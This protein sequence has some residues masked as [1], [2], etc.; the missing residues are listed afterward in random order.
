MSR[1][2]EFAAS[3]AYYMD[4]L[5]KAEEILT[6]SSVNHRFVGGVIVGPI[7]PQS[8]ITINTTEKTAVLAK[9]TP[10]T[11]LRNDGTARDIDVIGFSPDPET[12]NQAR[13][14]FDQEAW[15]AKNHRRPYPSISIESTLYPDWNPR[16]RLRQWV[17]T[18]DVDVSGKLHLT[19]GKVD[20]V[21]PWETM[22]PWKMSYDGGLELTT[23]NPFGLTK[24]YEMRNASGIKR[25]DRSKISDLASVCESVRQQALDQGVDFAKDFESWNQFIYNLQNHPDVLTRAKAV[26]TYLYWET[27][28]TPI[29][30][31]RGLLK[32]LTYFADKLTGEVFARN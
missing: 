13:R 16:N 21:I 15:I 32:P 3:Q 14:N 11:L 9:H 24:R 20:Q 31:G 1:G 8:T 27:V 5:S 4:L 28:G 12:Y 30:H 17:S 26:V 23:I 19:F 22:D 6:G 2:R 10:L 29:A 25:K 7:T 18:L